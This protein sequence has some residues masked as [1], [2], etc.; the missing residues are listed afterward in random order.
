M[1]RRCKSSVKVLR[2]VCEKCV[3]GLWKVRRGFVN[4]LR[5]V[6]ERFAKVLCRCAKS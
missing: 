1:R 5:R 2:W 6:C 3:K 4:V